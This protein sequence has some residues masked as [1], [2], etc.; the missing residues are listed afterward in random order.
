MNKDKNNTLHESDDI[1]ATA[2]KAEQFDT[3]LAAEKLT[4]GMKLMDE[5]DKLISEYLLDPDE[6]GLGFGENAVQPWKKEKKKK[7]RRNVKKVLLIIAAVILV[8]GI[9][10]GVVFAAINAN[11]EKEAQPAPIQPDKFP[12]VFFD[13][14]GNINVKPYNDSGYTA[15]S[16]ESTPSEQYGEFIRTNNDGSMLFFADRPVT[17]DSTQYDLYYRETKSS[18]TPS[19][20]EENSAGIN[21][22]KCIAKSVMG[23]FEVSNNG[24]YV[25]YLK[26]IADGKGKLYINNLSLETV[27]EE[28]DVTDFEISDDNNYILYRKNSGE[29]YGSLYVKSIGDNSEPQ[30]IDNNVVKVI[31]YTEDLSRIYYLRQSDL[32]AQEQSEEDTQS[33]D[34]ANQNNANTNSAVSD[35]TAQTGDTDK[36]ERSEVMC[37]LRLKVMGR[38]PIDIVDG[39]VNVS[40]ITEKGNFVFAMENKTV[41]TYDDLVEDEY[42]ETDKL[43]TR[44]NI[45]DYNVTTTV[46]VDENGDGKTESKE[47][48]KVDTESYNRA[49]SKWNEREKRDKTREELKSRNVEVINTGLYC[50]INGSVIEIAADCEQYYPIDIDN[51]VIAYT[52]R[53]AAPVTRYSLNQLIDN[54]DLMFDQTGKSDSVQLYYG[55]YRNSK[56]LSRTYDGQSIV[57][58]DGKLYYLDEYDATVGKGTLYSIDAQSDPVK[59]A[60]DVN[61]F[62]VSEMGGQY[63]YISNAA[64]GYG[65][66]FAINA[67]GERTLISNKVA[68]NGGYAI[69][70]AGNVAAA[71]NERSMMIYWDGN[72]VKDLA[73]NPGEFIFRDIGDLLY[74]ADSADGVTDTLFHFD[75]SN[76][77]DIMSGVA[78]FIL[79]Y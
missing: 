17:D 30:R 33:A 60:D 77:D 42:V 8:V 7:R 44:P 73:S 36:M 19:E 40:E 56:E 39:V 18:G 20:G 51:G 15:I 32:V 2:D 69:D 58:Q 25:V 5:E 9:G 23:K 52:Q 59:L 13:V 63:A 34:N 53:E 70:D 57:C 31:S 41:L 74:I 78:C 46:S 38:E 3:D 14:S 79:P 43:I 26:E 27:I 55:V 16:F 75:G 4:F 71:D 68:V 10:T 54:T 45:N 66:L 22:A 21:N 6:D 64:D 72:Q 29:A 11:N 62:A 49:L 65:E 1:E 61:S 48:T 76:A 28:H 50:F 67:K 12:I 37:S 35:E 24:E 47:V